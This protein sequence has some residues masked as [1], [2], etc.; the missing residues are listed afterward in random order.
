MHLGKLQRVGGQ[1]LNETKK[2]GG[3]KEEK[4]QQKNQT[5]ADQ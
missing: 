5:S 2:I 3:K 1:F 4:Y